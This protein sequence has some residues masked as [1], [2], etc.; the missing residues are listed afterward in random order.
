MITVNEMARFSIEAPRYTS[1]PT[2]AEFSAAIGEREFRRALAEV[3]VG[4]A[5][6]PIALYVHLPFCRAICH[7]CGCHALIARTPERIDGYL[8]ALG[9]EAGEVA[10]ALGGRR[11]VGELHFGGGSPS[12]LEAD[13]FEKMMRGLRAAFPFADD[14]TISIEA[15]PRTTDAEKL[16]RYRALGVGR[17]SF[18]FQDLDDGVQRAIG[19]N[20]S[21]EVSRRAF[22]LARDLGFEGINVDLCY[23]LPEQT[24]ATFAHTIAEVIAL[25]P[26]RVAIFG[27]AHVPWMKPMQRL[28]NAS[29]L[30]RAELRL[31]LMAAA[32]A[33]L[34]DGG[35]RAIG[36]DHFA[37]PHD[38]L[39]RAAEGG[40]LN[41]NFQGYT[42]T[43]VDA[44]IGLGLSAISDL[45]SG[46][47]QNQ[48]KLPD[49]HQ[50]VTR[51]GVAVERGVLR[52]GD[53]RLRGEIIRDLMCRFR[54]DMADVAQRFGISFEDR[55]APEL[56]ELR[57]LEEQGLVQVGPAMVDLTPLG[58]VFVRNVARVFDAYRR[59]PATAERPRFS[60]TG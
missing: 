37:L 44:L 40:T 18:G 6:A 51:P 50:V 34:I 41:R 24:E 4:D 10:R 5:R 28:I 46:Y 49:Y 52:T 45:P 19:R 31:R 56:D 15:D 9:A 3:G 39:A 11:R 55:F 23:G 35:Y 58:T 38:D 25:R 32:R 14:A 12:L 13:Q 48:R 20:Q 59:A 43:N 36:L 1:Y 30:P 57:A 54:L 53:D 22:A 2:A 8:A 42:T 29:A 60:S 17:I 33:A 7:F 16:R 47:F 26:D 21:A 27:Y